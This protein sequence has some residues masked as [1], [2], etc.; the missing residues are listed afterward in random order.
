MYRSDEEV[1]EWKKRDPVE[2][3]QKYLMQSGFWSEKE[4][5]VLE[6]EINREIL[7]AVAQAE[8]APP[9]PVETLFDD[10]F[11]EILPHLQEQKDSVISR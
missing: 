11:S 9:P 7:D 4:Q 2:R 3:M 5:A 10:V 1:E 8:S 6:E